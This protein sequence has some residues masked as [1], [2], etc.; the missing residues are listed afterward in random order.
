MFCQASCHASLERWSA[1][2]AGST[3]SMGA[4]RPPVAVFGVALTVQYFS[5]HSFYDG[6]PAAPA[7][8]P[9]PNRRWERRSAGGRE[10]AIVPPARRAAGSAYL[11]TAV[12]TA[13]PSSVT[14]Q[15]VLLA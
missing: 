1:L 6:G 12:T 15:V 14:V 7:S 11:N 2:V 3:C 5:S 9:A 8:P 4:C 13:L 10:R